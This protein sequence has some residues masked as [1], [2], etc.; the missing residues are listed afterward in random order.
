[1][2]FNSHRYDPH[3]Q[4]ISPLDRT[5]T[6]YSIQTILGPNARTILRI[7][8]LSLSVAGKFTVKVFNE[9]H[10]KTETF[11]LIVRSLPQV[12]LDVIDRPEAQ[13]GNLA[14]GSGISDGHLYKKGHE[15][16]L[17]CS[18]KGFPLPT[19]AWMFK[20]CSSYSSC[21]RKALPRQLASTYENQ[22]APYWKDGVLKIVATGSGRYICQACNQIDCAFKFI[23]FLGKVS[24]Q[25]T[26]EV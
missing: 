6:D 18:A 13:A 17:K 23:P 12:Q 24:E 22:K 21:D 16:T 4:I 9:G 19:I 2:C 15:Y 26:T 3:G 25:K 20:R 7:K 1:M 10:E 14:P 5:Q 11:E 8:R